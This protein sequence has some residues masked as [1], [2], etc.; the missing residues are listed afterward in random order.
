MRSPLTRQLPNRF[1]RIRGKPTLRRRFGPGL[2]A[3]APRILVADDNADLREYVKGL[4]DAHYSVE[5][6]PDGMA[7]LRAV[8]ARRPDLILSDVMM[9][10]LDGLGLLRALR[11]DALTRDIPII[12]LSA[13]AGEEAAI[14]G[15]EAGADDYLSKPFSARELGAR[16]RTHLNLAKARRQA[17]E[18][19]KA[20]AE[21]KIRHSQRWLS[22]GPG[23]GANGHMDL[24]L[25]KDKSERSFSTT[26]CS[27]TPGQRRNGTMP[28]S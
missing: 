14:D 2:E 21:E 1:R 18:L 17:E 3:C 7:A 11:A 4:L 8:K 5:A 9:P 24:D 10:R 23:V 13:R 20:R 6:V 25:I 22:L 26:N 27:A 16:I 15:I 28:S 19:T 12:L